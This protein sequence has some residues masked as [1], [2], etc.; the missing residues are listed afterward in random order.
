VQVADEIGGF[1][2]AR[3]RARVATIFDTTRE[4]L[5]LAERDGVPPAVAADHLAE[6]RM[7]DVGRLRKILVNDRNALRRRGGMGYPGAGG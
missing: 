2:F 6:R 7:A 4:I 5:A 3:A 1:D